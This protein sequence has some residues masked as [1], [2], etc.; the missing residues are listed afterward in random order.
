MS[1]HCYTRNR[2][3]SSHV[4]L[5]ESGQ[6]CVSVLDRRPWGFLEI[7]SDDSWAVLVVVLA[8]TVG[9][10][11]DPVVG[12]GPLYMGE[13][14]GMPQKHTALT[15]MLKKTQP[16][17]SNK[18]YFVEEQLFLEHGQALPNAFEILII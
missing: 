11:E 13:S 4:A 18:V 8:T 5:R 16:P 6:E 17:L 7:D 9:I 12:F 15:N 10:G 2:R 14:E 1:I 3:K